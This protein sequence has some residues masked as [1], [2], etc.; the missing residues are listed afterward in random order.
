MPVKLDYNDAD[1]KG[2]L[3]TTSSLPTVVRHEMA[4]LS[5]ESDLTI[6]TPI[7]QP[8]HCNSIAPCIGCK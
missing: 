6:Q 2:M 3:I 5:K 8:L 4:S 1:A 7:L